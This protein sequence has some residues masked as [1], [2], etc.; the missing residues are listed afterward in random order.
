[1]F[2]LAKI[3]F[4]ALAVPIMLALR[5]HLL[6]SFKVGRDSPRAPCAAAS[7]VS[8]PVLPAT[9][10]RL[11]NRPGFCSKRNFCTATPPKSTQEAVKQAKQPQKAS[12]NTFDK[13]KLGKESAEA[14]RLYRNKEHIGVLRLWNQRYP[15]RPG[16]V[17]FKLGSV[18]LQSMR[19]LGMRAEAVRLA[20]RL[21]EQFMR[22][23]VPSEWEIETLVPTISI[24]L[25]QHKEAKK[26]ETFIDQLAK[27]KISTAVPVFVLLNSFFFKSRSATKT[28]KYLRT[29]TEKYPEIAK[30][31]KRVSGLL[32]LFV[33]RSSMDGVGELVAY[34]QEHNMEFHGNA[35]KILLDAANLDLVAGENVEPY[36]PT[37]EAMDTNEISAD[38]LISLASSTRE[39]QF[40]DPQLA[41]DLWE[42]SKTKIISE[43]SAYKIHELMH[44]LIMNACTVGSVDA[45]IRYYLDSLKYE[46]RTA[47]ADRSPLRALFTMNHPRLIRF[48]ADHILKDHEYIDSRKDSLE[49]P[50]LDAS[51]LRR[52]RALASIVHNLLQHQHFES[53]LTLVPLLADD[54]ASEALQAK[55]AVNVAEIL[56]R[57][58]TPLDPEAFTN[59]Y[60]PMMIAELEKNDY[61]G[62]LPLEF[63]EPFYRDFTALLTRLVRLKA[64]KK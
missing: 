53:A 52:G 22:R 51:T 24:A 15:E 62:P 50:K 36:L 38:L 58:L 21:I 44:E 54:I 63:Y 11:V 23:P 34:M 14:Q 25:S 49:V 33:Q 60:F 3:T 13:T 46:V 41:I 8:A 56:R 18:T 64:A 30:E 39:K 40:G 35:V 7:Q 9:K 2:S 12:A 32:A 10:L 16:P 57:E 45:A 26:L 48:V 61:K 4:L 19:A 43:T 29:L 20:D 47:A 27:K 31:R 17:N 28:V 1:M 5:Q 37:I 55:Y 6:T 59:S 42:K